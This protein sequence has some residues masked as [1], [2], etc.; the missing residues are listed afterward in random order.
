MRVVVLLLLLTMPGVPSFAE[1]LAS[2]LTGN[3]VAAAPAIVQSVSKVYAQTL[4]GTVT[5]SDVTAG[6]CI[7]VIVQHTNF[8]GN[9]GGTTASDASSTR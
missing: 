3:S 9:G 6:N 1:S 4:T 5:I 2:G 8:G 7:V